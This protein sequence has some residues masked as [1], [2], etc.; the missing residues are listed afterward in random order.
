MLWSY[1][2]VLNNNETRH[3]LTHA[4]MR[5]QAKESAELGLITVAQIAHQ[6]AT[7]KLN[8]I[9]VVGDQSMPMPQTAL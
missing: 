9:R 7:T 6:S 4:V 1:V 8:A 2:S 5:R 3:T